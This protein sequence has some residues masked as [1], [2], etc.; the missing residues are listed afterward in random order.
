M[1]VESSYRRLL[2][3]FSDERHNHAAAEGEYGLY[4]DKKK[5]NQ[6]QEKEE[7][8]TQR[9]FYD[10]KVWQSQFNETKWI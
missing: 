5:A 8:S 1:K 3:K 9:G 10:L 6:A 2:Q 4:Y 7:E